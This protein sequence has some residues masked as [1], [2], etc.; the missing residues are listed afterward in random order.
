MSAVSTVDTNLLIHESE[1]NLTIMKS[2]VSKPRQ[3]RRRCDVQQ[4]VAAGVNSSKVK[5]RPQ[6]REAIASRT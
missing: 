2:Q 6:L 5:R 4:T 3:V 1:I